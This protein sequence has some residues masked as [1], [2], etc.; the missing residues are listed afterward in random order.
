MRV[1]TYRTCPW[2]IKLC[3]PK[4]FRRARHKALEQ[5]ILECKSRYMQVI[6]KVPDRLE[7][8]EMTVL[9]QKQVSELQ[10]QLSYFKKQIRYLECCEAA[11]HPPLP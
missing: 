10:S 6:G 7:L 5:H 4:P 8:F 9:L 3:V 1:Q 11:R 2:C